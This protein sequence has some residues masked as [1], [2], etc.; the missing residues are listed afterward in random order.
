MEQLKKSLQLHP[1]ILA[2][3]ERNMKVAE[4]LGV[5]SAAEDA[6][7]KGLIERGASMAFDAVQVDLNNRASRIVDI[8]FLVESLDLAPAI[9]GK[10]VADLK[11]H[12]AEVAQQYGQLVQHSVEFVSPLLTSQ[13]GV[14]I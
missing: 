5:L 10:L 1:H 12:Q 8:L 11:K 2:A 9:K 4:K 14:T 7:R 3:L 13:T 6:Q